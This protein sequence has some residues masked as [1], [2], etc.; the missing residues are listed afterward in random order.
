MGPVSDFAFAF[1]WFL[2]LQRPAKGDCATRYVF[3]N[4]S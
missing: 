4:N 2:R 1:S 3:R